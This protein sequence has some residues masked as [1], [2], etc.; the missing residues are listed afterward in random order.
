[1]I[2]RKYSQARGTKTFKGY[3]AKPVYG[4]K[5]VGEKLFGPR[6]KMSAIEWHDK[7]LFYAKSGTDTRM[8]LKEAF[9][10]YVA[11][12]NMTVQS[13]L[14]VNKSLRCIELDAP[15][16]LSKAVIELRP[17]DMSDLLR[18]IFDKSAVRL[19]KPRMHLK[20]E[21][22]CL[23][24]VLEYYRYAKNDSFTNPITKQHKNRWAK[25]QDKAQRYKPVHTLSVDEVRRLLSWL[26]GH[27]DPVH[28]HIA[29][30]Q[31]TSHRQRLGEVL[32]LEWKD[33]DWENETIWLTGTMIWADETGKLLRNTK[34]YHT[35]E[36]RGAVPIYFGGANTHLKR[37][38]EGLLALR[39]DLNPWVFA[40]RKGN[41]PTLRT[42][43][44][45]YNK[46][47]FFEEKGLSSHKCRKTAITQALLLCGADA[48]MVHGGHSTAQA[49]ARYLDKTRIEKLNPAPAALAS[50][51]FES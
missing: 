3:L 18:E 20:R 30:W 32:S 11:S 4:G 35:K 46:S 14:F 27:R 13:K 48:A 28:Y 2:V 45:V 31:L 50:E 12:S 40:D 5:V 10:E 19:G 16:W 9:I 39:K 23:R 38:L 41:V 15:K 8:T 33:V 49:H 37:S 21:V 26:E 22:D 42:V 43:T 29:L 47:G 7:T 25:E 34:Q 36:G 6:E 24:C 44:S 51:V 17:N 1:M